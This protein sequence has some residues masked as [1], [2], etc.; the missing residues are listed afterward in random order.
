MKTNSNACSMRRVGFVTAANRWRQSGRSSCRSHDA[1]QAHRKHFAR[2]EGQGFGSALLM[3]DSYAWS[4]SG[5]LGDFCGLGIEHV[6]D[7]WIA[8]AILTGS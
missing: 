8:P 6:V 2:I 3:C 7:I 1:T 5:F 4:F